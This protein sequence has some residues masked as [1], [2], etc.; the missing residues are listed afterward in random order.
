MQ[1]GI[2]TASAIRHAVR[3]GVMMYLICCLLA[4]ARVALV[5]ED[6]WRNWPHLWPTKASADASRV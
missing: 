5:E 6:D 4:F 3:A 2:S 1:S